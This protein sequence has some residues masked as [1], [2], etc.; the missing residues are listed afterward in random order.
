[1]SMRYV[2]AAENMTLELISACLRPSETLLR[3]AHSPIREV[4]LNR[5]KQIVEIRLSDVFGTMA[6]AGRVSA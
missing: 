1:M 3:Y 6:S 4:M 2:E 5:A